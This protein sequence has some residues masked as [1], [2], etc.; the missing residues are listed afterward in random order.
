MKPSRHLVGSTFFALVL[1]PW[2][3]WR[4]LLV[5][6]G[7]AL[8]DLDR[9]LWHAL[10]HR[11]LRLSSAMRQFHGRERIRGDPRFLHSLEFIILVGLAGFVH[12]L[13]WIFA[14]GVAFHVLLDLFIHKEHGR[15]VVRFE[16]WRLH[17]LTIGWLRGS[18]SGSAGGGA[19]DD[20]P[21]GN[22]R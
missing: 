15:F 8:L 19:A 2:L 16:P 18:D 12:P 5:L 7:G 14:L 10:R 6:A 3:T 1:A 9:Y 11:T 22:S 21:S 20:R 4:A 17:C 13:V